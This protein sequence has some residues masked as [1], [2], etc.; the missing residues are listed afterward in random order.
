MGLA[1]Q[2]IRDAVDEFAA[3][4][5]AGQR[6]PALLKRSDAMLTELETLNLMEVQR[7][8]ATIRSALTALVADLPFDYTPRLGP[9][10]TPTA[11]I[12]VVFTIQDGILNL[13]YGTEPSDQL[14]EVAS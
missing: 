7:T 12:N 8:P 3:E 10:P 14:L 11:A 4:R 2:E 5:L 13:I 6:L 1:N 9:R